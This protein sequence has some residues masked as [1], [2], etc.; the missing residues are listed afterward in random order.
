MQPPTVRRIRIVVMTEAPA[1]DF[2]DERNIYFLFSNVDEL[3]VS[4]ASYLYKWIS[5]RGSKSC[6]NVSNTKTK[7]Y[8]HYPSKHTIE[9]GSPHHGKRKDARGVLELFS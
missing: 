8:K 6:F 5:G 7:S 9:D 1:W 2:V 4:R 3:M